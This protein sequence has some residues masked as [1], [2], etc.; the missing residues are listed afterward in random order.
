M[1]SARVRSSSGHPIAW[2]DGPTPLQVP[3][4]RPSGASNVQVTAGLRHTRLN[5]ARLPPHLVAVLPP[6]LP[7]EADPAPIAP[8]PPL[9]SDCCDS[10]CDPCVNDLY[11]EE[12]QLYRSQLAAWQAR[13]PGR[14]P[15][16]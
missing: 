2:A 10:G 13:N 1:H 8:E 3:W 5:W 11:T 9:P 14:N 4:T 15:G 7:P 12:L 6:V 16:D